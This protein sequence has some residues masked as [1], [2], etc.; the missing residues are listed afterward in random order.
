MGGLA[1]INVRLRADLAKFSTDMQNANRQ[2]AKMGKEM[3]RV[4]KKF[5][6]GLTAPIV[7]VGAAALNTFSQLEGVQSAFEKLNNQI[8]LITAK[9]QI[10]ILYKDALISW[11]VSQC[12]QKNLFAATI[13]WK[14]I[15]V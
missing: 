3:N 6:V 1:S 9:L 4:G 7:A 13:V 8:N 10:D 12:H 14:C 2:I 5:S 15:S 11:Y